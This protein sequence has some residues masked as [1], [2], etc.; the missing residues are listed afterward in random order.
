MKLHLPNDSGVTPVENR[1]I[2]LY[3]PSANGEFV[4]LYLYLLRC[5]YSG[6]DLSVSSIADFFDHTEKDVR[7]AL[8]YWEKLSLLQL[9]YDEDGNI[10]DLYFSTE[11]SSSVSGTVSAAGPLTLSVPDDA[12]SQATS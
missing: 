7:R 3:M 5:A 2:D 1:F 8:A 12:P 9:Q 11:A 4:K 6:R 10:T